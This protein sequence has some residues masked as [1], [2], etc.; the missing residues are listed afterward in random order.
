MHAFLYCCLQ[1]TFLFGEDFYARK[2]VRMQQ[3]QAQ[4]NRDSLD[5]FDSSRIGIP[6]KS[7]AS[8]SE[9]IDGHDLSKK[10]EYLPDDSVDKEGVQVYNSPVMIV[11]SY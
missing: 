9:L 5:T 4:M 7:K 1:N 6:S 10:F 3:L 8:S 11:R 2:S